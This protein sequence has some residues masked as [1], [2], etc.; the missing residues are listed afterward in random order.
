MRLLGCSLGVFSECCCEVV[1][2]VLG[3]FVRV[4]L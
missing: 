3:V 4:L 2:Y 1:K